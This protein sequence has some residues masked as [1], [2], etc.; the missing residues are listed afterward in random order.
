MT[1]PQQYRERSLGRCALLGFQPPAHL[2]LRPSPTSR[3]VECIVDR[4]MVLYVMAGLADPRV[5]PAKILEWLS[6]HGLLPKRT[7]WE[8]DCCQHALDRTLTQSQ[9]A[10]LSWCAESLGC[11]LWA[12][13]VA[14]DMP[15]PDA[16]F[17]LE[18]LFAKIPP[19]IPRSRLVRT[20]ISRPIDEVAAEAD[21]VYCLHWHRVDSE[22]RGV[23]Q[24]I[25]LEQRRALEW[26]TTGD[27][28]DDVFL[29]T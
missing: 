19:A 3:P 9:L 5:N 1:E 18:P 20:A 10:A 16:P 26:L 2:P 25:A 22:T 4:A 23:C 13:S 8:A 15:A 21:F 11:L 14:S 17:D 27:T 24:S 12:I 29:D 7:R 28:W 6:E